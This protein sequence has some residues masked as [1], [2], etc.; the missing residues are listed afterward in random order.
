MPRNKYQTVTVLPP[1]SQFGRGECVIYQGEVLTSDGVNWTS[2]TGPLTYTADT[3]PDLASL[4]VGAVVDVDNK[5]FVRSD[6][7]LVALQ[8]PSIFDV[9]AIPGIDLSGGTDMSSLIQDA[10]TTYRSIWIPRGGSILV[11]NIQMPADTAIFGEGTLLYPNSASNRCITVNGDKC[12]ISGLKFK[13]AEAT[14]VSKL[15]VYVANGVSDTIIQDNFFNGVLNSSFVGYEQWVVLEQNGQ[16]NKILRNTINNGGFGIFAKNPRSNYIIE[17]IINS[18]VRPIQIYS[19]SYNK[20]NFNT[21]NGRNKHYATDTGTDPQATIVGINFL[22]FGVF[23][24]NRGILHN[25]VIGNKVYGVAEEAI[26]MDTHGNDTSDSAENPWLRVGTVSSVAAT[27]VGRYT[28]TLAEPVLQGGAAAPSNWW[29]ETYII[30]MAGTNQGAIAKCQGGTSSTSANTST[31]IVPA[32]GGQMFNIGDKLLFTYGILF[33]TFTNNEIRNCQT[34]LY[35]WGSAWYNKIIGNHVAGVG[36]GI[37][38][39]TVI[40]NLINGAAA[41]GSALGGVQGFSG[42]NIISHNTIVENF[43]DQPSTTTKTGYPML[44]GVWNYGSTPAVSDLNFGNTFTDNMISA[45]KSA[46]LGFL[47]KNA[48]TGCTISKGAYFN[49]NR[50][51]GGGTFDTTNASGFTLGVNFKG[52]STTL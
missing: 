13:C 52:L 29:E 46:L 16:R 17:N 4:P 20:V 21:I 47:G 6:N 48:V 2:Q 49:G 7:R 43:Y 3:L 40:D 36:T 10:L 30:C 12:V 37:G 15:I 35:L 9:S 28:I 19:G 39:C 14:S 33:N 22:T 5:A 27:G 23:G 45:K 44:V 42:C 34:G 25:Q 1:A 8:P 11:D 24:R 26:S 38:I 32:N 31:I 50:I 51:S 41:D 18:T